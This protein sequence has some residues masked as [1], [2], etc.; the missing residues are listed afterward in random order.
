[1]QAMCAYD[2]RTSG[3]FFEVVCIPI[4]TTAYLFDP[5]AASRCANRLSRMPLPT[6]VSGADDVLPAPLNPVVEMLGHELV[7]VVVEAVVYAVDVGKPTVLARPLSIAYPSLG[8]ACHPDAIGIQTV[9]GYF[10]CPSFEAASGRSHKET[11]ACCIVSLTTPTRSPLNVSRPVSLRNWAE[12]DSR[13]FLV[14]Y[15]LL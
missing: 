14:S 15:F 7:Y 5:P 13:V 9:A 1:M 12:K 2:R 4:T 10:T 8:E 6:M 11:W 3:W